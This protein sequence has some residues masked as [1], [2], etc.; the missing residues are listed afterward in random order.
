MHHAHSHAARRRR[1]EVQLRRAEEETLL[2][3]YSTTEMNEDW[4]FKIVRGSFSDRSSVE[5]VIKEQQAFGWIYVEKFDNNRIRFK[6]SAAEAL[7]DPERAG[8]PY[9]TSSIVAGNG[10]AV[11]LILTL[12]IASA[13]TLL[14]R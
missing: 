12:F 7:K 6:R 2:T 13:A 10:C 8:D 5:A 1:R 11:I 4:Q 9:S 3:P 14:A